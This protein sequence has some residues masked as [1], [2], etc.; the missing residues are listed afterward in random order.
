MSLLEIF[1]L[2][3]IFLKNR[4]FFFL[5]FFWLKR[6]IVNDRYLLLEKHIFSF[7]PI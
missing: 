6:K 2:W 1:M 3:T 4:P 5:F 7:F